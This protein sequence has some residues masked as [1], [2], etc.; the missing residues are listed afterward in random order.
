MVIWQI[1]CDVTDKRQM[2]QADS[3]RKMVEILLRRGFKRQLKDDVPYQGE[4]LEYTDVSGRRFGAMPHTI[5]SATD[6]P[7]MDSLSI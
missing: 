3:D 1:E 5:M 4:P 7:H 6:V 2:I